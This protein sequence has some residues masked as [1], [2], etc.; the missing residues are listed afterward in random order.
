MFDSTVT[1]KQSGHLSKRFTNI[2]D[3]SDKGR[4]KEHNKSYI[5]G[6]MDVESPNFTVST[7]SDRLHVAE[8][9]YL[10]R[11]KCDSRTTTKYRY[12]DNKKA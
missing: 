4:N 3:A 10:K 8:A 5:C 12:D 7:G 2:K 9:H 1:V 11:K 6:Q